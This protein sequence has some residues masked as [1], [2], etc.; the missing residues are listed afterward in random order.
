MATEHD[1]RGYPIYL[2]EFRY[3]DERTGKSR[4]ARHR[5]ALDTI[6]Q[7]HAEY[8]TVGEPM[9]I[10]EPLHGMFNPAKPGVHR[11]LRGITGGTNGFHG[12][13]S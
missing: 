12:G 11:A 9:V 10:N 5:A 4:K 13:F 7:E 2:Y 3:R 8:E 1:S 6:R